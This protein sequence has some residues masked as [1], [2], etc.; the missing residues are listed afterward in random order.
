MHENLK[1]THEATAISP[2]KTKLKGNARNLISNEQTIAA[3]II[4]LSSAVKGESVDSPE[5]YYYYW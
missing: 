4:Q 2:I 1:G 3:I 5:S